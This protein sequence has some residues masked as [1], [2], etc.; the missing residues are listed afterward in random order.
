MIYNVVFAPILFFFLTSLLEYN[1]FTMVC[2]FLLYNKVNQLYIYIMS[3]Y[4]FPLRSLVSHHGKMCVALNLAFLHK[5]VEESVDCFFNWMRP[6][7]PFHMVVNPC[8][9]FIFICSFGIGGGGYKERKGI[10]VTFGDLF[11]LHPR[12]HPSFRLESSPSHLYISSLSGEPVCKHAMPS[13]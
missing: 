4:L 9:I 2:Q 5:P 10:V 8:Y 1:C 7:F 13:M 3:P 11:F 6:Y 12:I